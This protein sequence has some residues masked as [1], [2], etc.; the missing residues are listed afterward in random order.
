MLTKFMLYVFLWN[1]EA[2][3][4]PP[5]FPKMKLVPNKYIVA[6]A[7]GLFFAALA[8]A[9]AQSKNGEP[10]SDQ[11]L[12]AEDKAKEQQA[13]E[14][15]E[16]ATRELEEAAKLP[17]GAGQPECL[18]LGRRVTSL[19]WRDDPDAAKRF[20]DLY[21]RWGCPAD[22]L[23]AAFRCVVRMGPIDQKAP[24]KLAGRVHMCWVRPESKP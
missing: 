14:A 18:W 9:F 13:K 19:L 5:E 8:P 6:L 12:S 21:D 2:G 16:R 24:Q 23:K 11:Q 3:S 1:E 15:Q 10:K 4:F 17:K 7:G 20:M 22:H